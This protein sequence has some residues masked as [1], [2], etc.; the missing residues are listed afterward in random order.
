[1]HFPEASHRVGNSLDMTMIL[2]NDIVEVLNLPNGKRP[3]ACKPPRLIKS[4]LATVNRT[5]F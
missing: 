5:I 1:M 4:D 3:F 2:F